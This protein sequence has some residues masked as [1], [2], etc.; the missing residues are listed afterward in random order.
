MSG[1]DAGGKIGNVVELRDHAAKKGSGRLIP[2][3]PAR[4]S[5]GSGRLLS[6]NLRRRTVLAGCVIG[7]V[8]AIRPQLEH[9]PTWR[10]HRDCAA[11]TLVTPRLSAARPA[12]QL[13][14]LGDAPG[15]VPGEQ[16]GHGASVPGLPCP[17]ADGPG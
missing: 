1:A 5:L 2:M 10:G 9:K 17:E 6:Q 13:Q 15:L 12:Q 8:A 7:R 14:Q 11:A 4:L 16:L 3:H